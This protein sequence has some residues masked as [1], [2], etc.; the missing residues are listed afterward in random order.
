M[1]FIA[2]NVPQEREQFK[3]IDTKDVKVK[4]AF[5]NYNKAL[6]LQNKG[7]YGKAKEIYEELMKIDI[8]N[9]DLQKVKNIQ[10]SPLHLVRYVVLKNYAVILEKEN[11]IHEA[12]EY[13]E[14]AILIDSTDT[15]LWYRIGELYQHIDFYDSA[16]NAYKHALENSN[17]NISSWKAL[18]GISN[19]LYEI[20][21][22]ITC[23][24]YVNKALNINSSWVRGMWIKYDILWEFTQNLSFNSTLPLRCTFSDIQ[25]FNSKKDELKLLF[26]KY[27][28]ETKKRKSECFS[29]LAHSCKDLSYTLDNNNWKELGEL[30]LKIYNT[31]IKKKEEIDSCVLAPVKIKYDKSNI[32]IKSPSESSTS[33][34]NEELKNDSNDD[35]K[36]TSNDKKR[37]RF[38]SP[39]EDKKLVR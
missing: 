39:E 34:S 21:D 2:F 24:K 26:K 13:Y 9:E 16:Y 22:F 10:S 17:T 11:N 30:L 25:E 4:K 6:I 32:P 18:T 20:G 36:A 19:V 3:E 12:I 35:A 1:R 38:L 28:E 23:L 15:N 29:K 8:F 27:P 33:E 37:K 7:E 31:L 14:K 5:E